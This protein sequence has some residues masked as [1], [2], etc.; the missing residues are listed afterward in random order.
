MLVFKS[1]VIFKYFSD[2][3]KKIFIL[4]FLCMCFCYLCRY[5]QSPEKG[6]GSLGTGIIGYCELPNVGAGN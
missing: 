1:N 5:T 4:F 6:V 2:L 3:K